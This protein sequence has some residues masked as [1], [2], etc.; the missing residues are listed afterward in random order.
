[1]RYFLLCLLLVGCTAAPVRNLPEQDEPPRYRN[2]TVVIVPGWLWEH[3]G[4]ADFGEYRSLLKR[5][6][7]PHKFIKT[8]SKA[9]QEENAKLIRNA[10]YDIRGPL[11]LVTG[12]RGTS[13]AVIALSGELLPGDRHK[14]PDVANY[15]LNIDL[16]VNVSGAQL[17]TP[18]ADAWTEPRWIW[19]TPI[20]AFFAGSNYEAIQGMT[21]ERSRARF[22]RLWPYVPRIP[23]VSI[24]TR[25]STNQGRGFMKIAWEQMA[26]NKP[27]DGLIRC[28]DQPL[29]GSAV[30]EVES[31]HML[32]SGLQGWL[33]N[34]E[35]NRAMRRRL[36]VDQTVNWSFWASRTPLIAYCLRYFDLRLLLCGSSRG[37][38]LAS[39]LPGSGI[40][41]LALLTALTMNIPV[42]ASLPRIDTDDRTI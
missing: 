19:G 33:I 35:I 16:W 26:S 10:I 31:P 9:R 6:G 14:P 18:I 15:H 8:D 17:G 37:R 3:G 7:V 11:I 34:R 21:T 42:L 25:D 39:P 13:E 41:S 32:E 2:H 22:L 12:S 5:W 23:T 28:I 24:V 27:H 30:L 38:A 4:Q 36:P 40:L 1:M 29:P 20:W